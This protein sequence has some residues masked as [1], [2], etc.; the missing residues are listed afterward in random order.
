M[1]KT[2][3]INRRAA[4]TCI[5]AAGFSIQSTARAQGYLHPGVYVEEIPS[6]TQRAIRGVE[7][8]I[9]AFVGVASASR[10]ENDIVSVTSFQDAERYIGGRDKRLFP[11]M[12]TALRSFFENGGAR[13]LIVNAAHQG[14]DHEDQGEPL[15]LE[16]LEVLSEADDARF[17]LLYLPTAEKYFGN[18]L[19][20]LTILYRRAL[21]LAQN[22]KAMLLIDG[23]I[24]PGEAAAWRSSLGIDDPDIAAFAPR[25]TAHDCQRAHYGAGGAIS[26]LIA[27]TDR[28]R[29]VWKAPAGVDAY[30]NGSVL[31]TQYTTGELDVLYQNNINPIRTTPSSAAPILWG[32]RTM[33]SD[34]EWKYLSVRRYFRYLEASIDEGT[35]WA[36]FEANDVS[37]WSAIKAAVDTFM[38]LQFRSGGLVGRRTDEAYYVRC[39]LG[40]SMT[41]SDV[42][43]GRLVIEVGFA[44]LRPSEFLIFRVIKNIVS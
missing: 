30:I 17:N 43:N 29:G 20:T 18:A 31:A 22:R 8:S 1:S 36:V 19:S 15:L 38:Q 42:D 5:S 10:P 41:Q 39:G 35:N 7:T 40:Q 25:L 28:N 37:T 24:K 26:G 11:S 21:T 34:P 16:A 3:L 4:I 6:G 2:R 44:A 9:A 23:E 14:G 13:A 27:R 33:S 12:A 32:S